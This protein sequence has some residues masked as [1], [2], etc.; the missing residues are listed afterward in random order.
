[1]EIDINRPE[2]DLLW[3]RMSL[4]TKKAYRESYGAARDTLVKNEVQDL[5]AS[6]YAVCS[7]ADFTLTPAG[8]GLYKKMTTTCKKSE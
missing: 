8:E 2:H 3:R 6:G 5:V 1:M 4:M 7:G